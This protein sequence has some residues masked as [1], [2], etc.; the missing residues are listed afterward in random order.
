MKSFDLGILFTKFRKYVGIVGVVVKQ[1][2]IFNIGFGFC[3]F[4]SIWEH[5]LKIFF[6]PKPGAACAFPSGF[7][8]LLVVSLHLFTPVSHCRAEEFAPTLSNY[9]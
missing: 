6:D 4:N 5:R 9:V 8:L 3:V 7:F 2:V 1:N